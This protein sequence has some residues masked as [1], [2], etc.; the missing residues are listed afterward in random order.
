MHRE[1]IGEDTK[2]YIQYRCDMDFPME[3]LTIELFGD[4]KIEPEPMSDDQIVEHAT[5]KIKM[6]KEMLISTGFSDKLLQ[7][8]MVN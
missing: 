1:E 7:A 5:K 4:C 8:C 3:N 6:L 2:D